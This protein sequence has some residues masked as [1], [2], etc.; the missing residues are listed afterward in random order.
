MTKKKYLTAA[1]LQVLSIA[2]ISIVAGVCSNQMRSSGIPLVAAWTIEERMAD[3]TGGT[4][5][6]PIFEAEAA[7]KENRAIFL[8][9]RDETAF[10]QGHITGAKNLPWH[11][12]DDY[13]ME[14]IPELSPKTLIIA[15]CD[16]ETCNLSHD[17]AVLLKEMGFSNAKVLVNG[18]TVWQEA[19]LPVETGMNESHA[20]LPQRENQ[21]S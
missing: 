3:E 5:I 7:F 2:V 18:W 17:L 1:T 9:A 8:D 10:S 12:V 6:I 4:M 13:L 15:Y 14:I 16:G 20:N 21:G 19:G 11:Q